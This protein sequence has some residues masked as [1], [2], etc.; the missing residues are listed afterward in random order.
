[1]TSWGYLLALK[2]DPH[3][4]DRKFDDGKTLQEHYERTCD[5]VKQHMQQR[6]RKGFLLEIATGTYSTRMHNMWYLIHAISPDA[7]LRRLARNT[8]DLYWTFWAEEE[9]AGE[10]GGGKVR[11]RDLKGLGPNAEGHLIGPS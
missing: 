10:R 5:Y 4:K 9:L 8:L 3:F 6:A 7:N 2:D 11:H 1:V